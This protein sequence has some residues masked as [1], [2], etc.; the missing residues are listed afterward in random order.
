MAVLVVEGEV[1]VRSV[2]I[3]RLDPFANGAIWTS[4]VRMGGDYAN[5]AR[6][7]TWSRTG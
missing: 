1:R 7:T 3:D 5:L 6:P 2:G 4:T